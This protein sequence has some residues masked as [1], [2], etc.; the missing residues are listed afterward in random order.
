MNE[1]Q[2]TAAAL[3][4][5]SAA[6]ALLGAMLV[7]GCAATGIAVPAGQVQVMTVAAHGV[8][9]HECRAQPGHPAAWAFVAP[10]ADLFDADGRR[11]GH[12]G[13][14]PTWQHEDGSGFAGAV[15]ASVPSPDPTAI[16]WL[17]LSATPQAAPGAFSRVAAV[18]RVN[19][20][21]GKPPTF[22]CDTSTLGR[23][24]HM[25]YRAD[26]VLHVPTAR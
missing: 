9:I 20:V 5:A 14:G 15:R 18:Q 10:D 24:V 8:Q 19:T 12:H 7:A 21:G 1:R 4:P 26:Y 2:K 23:R 16:A 22:G 6:G 3:N 13:A 25:A 11:I 17:L